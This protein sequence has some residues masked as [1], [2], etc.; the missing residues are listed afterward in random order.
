MARSSNEPSLF[1][2]MMA[3]MKDR[4]HR[5][6]QVIDEALD[7]ENLKDRIWAVEQIL[8]RIKPGEI[9]PPPPPS[10]E[11]PGETDTAGAPGA[12]PENWRDWDTDTLLTTLQEYLQ[13][14][15][16]DKGGTP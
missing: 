3:A 9:E 1:A 6:L 8:K 16:G 10:G 11:A 15:P 7:S 2:R 4:T 13:S 12:L 5:V 14:P